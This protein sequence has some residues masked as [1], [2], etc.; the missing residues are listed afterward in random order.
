MINLLDVEISVHTNVL[1]GLSLTLNIVEQKLEEGLD[2]ITRELYLNEIAI[3]VVNI[4]E[5]LK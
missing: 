2:K 5:N 3:N 1:N 4:L